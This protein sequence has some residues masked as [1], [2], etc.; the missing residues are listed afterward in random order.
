VK[1][2]YQYVID[3]RE[4]PE[5]TCKITQQQLSKIQDR[6]Q[7]YYNRHAKSR[8]LSVGDSVL[9]LL[10][11]TEYNNLTLAWRG[12]Y[13]VVEKLGDVDYRVAIQ[14]GKMKTYH[15]NM[16]KRYYRRNQQVTDIQKPV[17]DDKGLCQHID[18]TG[19]EQKNDLYRKSQQRT[20]VTIREPEVE[21]VLSGSCSLCH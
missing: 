2:G 17:G 18:K 6:N 9:L 21:V 1:T 19:S 7:K 4:R 8:Y 11:P 16:L 5:E 12:P 14:P 13:K 10:L 20:D 15:I 3:L